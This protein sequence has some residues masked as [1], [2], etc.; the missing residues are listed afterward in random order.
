M[1]RRSKQRS[2]PRELPAHWAYRPGP[3]SYRRALR[4]NLRWG[5]AW[6]L[7]AAVGF[8]LW[9]SGIALLR[10]STRFEQ[11][12]VA[13]GT[14]IVT[15]LSAG[16]VGGVLLGL[17]RPLLR[18]RLGSVVVGA[19][20]GIAFYTAIGISVDG[21]RLE[22]F[23]LGAAIGV[24]GGGLAGAFWWERPTADPGNPAA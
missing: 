9:A 8:S 14:V 11:Y 3:R 5:L 23:V 7:T 12:G 20:V 17:G 16:V 6:G 22:T 13:L 10:G 19:L 24:L 21:I 1:G 18:W 15:Y 2:G 4:A